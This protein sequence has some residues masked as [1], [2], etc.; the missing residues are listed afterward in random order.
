M[1]ILF[2]K[3]PFTFESFLKQEG[4]DHTASSAAVVST[5]DDPTKHKEGRGIWTKQSIQGWSEGFYFQPSILASQFVNC[6]LWISF[7]SEGYDKYLQATLNHRQHCMF[8]NTVL[9]LKLEAEDMRAS[10]Q[11]CLDDLIPQPRIPTLSKHTLLNMHSFQADCPNYF[12][13]PKLVEASNPILITPLS[14]GTAHSAKPTPKRTGRTTRYRSPQ[15]TTFYYVKSKHGSEHRIRRINR[16]HNLK[17]SPAPPPRG[18]PGAP[19]ANEECTP[20]GDAAKTQSRAPYAGGIVAEHT[21]YGDSCVTKQGFPGRAPGTPPHSRSR[22]PL[23]P[24]RS[25]SDNPCY[26]NRPS[27]DKRSARSPTIRPHRL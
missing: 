19:V 7:S 9:R 12:N 22:K 20:P 2:C 23:A 5:L 14:Q 16:I 26:G 24:Q 8:G 10:M 13:P 15:G 11:L 18:T 25:G 1:S 4:P 6:I 21:A 17:N 27:S 3:V